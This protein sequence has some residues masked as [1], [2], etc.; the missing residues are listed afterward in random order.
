MFVPTVDCSGCRQFRARI[1][2]NL[3]RNSIYFQFA[4][5]FLFTVQH[6]LQQPA[7]EKTKQLDGQPHD[8][9]LESDSNLQNIC[10]L[11]RRAVPVAAECAQRFH[12]P[13][14]KRSCACAKNIKLFVL[15]IQSIIP[16]CLVM[17]HFFEFNRDLRLVKSFST[18]AVSAKC[19]DE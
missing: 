16:K 15:S 7:F 17:Q 14:A 11:D 19:H 5:E 12:P 6:Q 4:N 10:A 1:K 3:R 9:H 8:E 2:Q 18:I 13:S